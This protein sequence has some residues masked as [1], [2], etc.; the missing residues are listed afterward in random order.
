MSYDMILD[1]GVLSD[2]DRRQ[3]ESNVPN[4]YGDD[5]LG[6][7]AWLDQQL[8]SVRGLRSVFRCAL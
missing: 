4:L 6:G 7:R 1:M 3:I 5:R 2:D 8:E